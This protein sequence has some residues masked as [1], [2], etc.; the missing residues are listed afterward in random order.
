MNPD[1]WKRLEEIYHS[2][3]QRDSADRAA[4]LVET[5]GSDEELRLEIESLL[6]H[7]EI[8]SKL[9]SAVQSETPPTALPAAATMVGPIGSKGVSMREAWASCIARWTLAF[10]ARSQSRSAWRSFPTGSIA[11]HEWW[12]S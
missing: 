4:Y 11:K 12:Q 6:A 1:C 9:E 2:A 10:A 5:C 3:R 8:L 7:G